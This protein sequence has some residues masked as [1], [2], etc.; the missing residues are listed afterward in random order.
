MKYYIILLGL[1]LISALL[2]HIMKRWS[3]LQRELYKIIDEN[4]GFRIHLS[5]YRM[6]SQH[7]SADLPRYWI[8]LDDEIIFDYPKQ[9]VFKD[10][11]GSFIKNLSGEKMYYPYQTDIPDISALIREYIDT[12]KDEVFSKHFDNDHWGLINILKAADRRF[13]RTRLDLLQ[14]RMDNKAALKVLERR[15]Q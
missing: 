13:G 9:F 11:T 15:K 12:P 8:T 10:E 3:S 7:G 14:K 5:V 4:I 6:S 1:V 2:C